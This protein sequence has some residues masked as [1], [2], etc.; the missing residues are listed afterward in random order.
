MYEERLLERIGNLER[1]PEE[2]GGRNISREVNSIIHHLQRMLNTRQGSVPIHD[3]YGIPDITNFPGDDLTEMAREMEHA[4][5]VVIQKYEP[6]LKKIRV[7][8][9]PQEDVVLALKFKIDAYLVS[10]ETVPVAFET[11]VN[12]EGKI[13][14][15]D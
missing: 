13:D 5:Q 11:E 2:R 7:Q 3:D 12:S 15:S 6:R 14:V 1:H 4:I 8:F 9:S 10:E